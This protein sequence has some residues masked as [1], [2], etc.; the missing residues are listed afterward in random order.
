M[1]ETR[2]TL[3]ELE[4]ADDFANRHIGP[5]EAESIAM[6]KTLGLSSLDE[7]VEKT[8]PGKIR[9]DLPDLPEARSEAQVLAKLRELAGRNQPLTS[10]IGQG[11]HDCILPPVIQRNLLENPGW[12]TAYTPYQAEIAQGRLEALI[13]FQQMVVDLTGLDLAN[14][15]MLDEA[16]AVAE[17]M[18]LMR[19]VG[20]SKSARCF[21]ADDMHPQTLAV[22][23]TRAKPLGIEL[24]IGAPDS[25]FDASDYFGVILQYPNTYG[26]IGDHGKLVERC[27]EGGALVTVASDLLSL[28]KLT[29]PGEW[30]AD[31]VVGSAQRFGVPMAYGGPHAAF[32]A[33]R[34]AYKRS[35]PGRIVGVST[36]SNGDPAL[37]LALQT[38]EQHIR[39]EKATSNICTAQVLLAVIA[40]FYAVWHGPLGLK[41]IANRVHRFTGILAQGLGKLGYEVVNDSWFDT[42]TVKAGPEVLQRAREA[43]INLRPVDDS[44]VGISLDEITTRATL[45]AVL[46]VFADKQD[47]GLDLLKLDEAADSGIPKALQRKSDYLTHPVFNSYHSETEMLRYLR[48]LR[49]KDIALDRSMIPLGSCTMKLN[50]AAE[51][52]AI[53]LP[54]FAAMHPFAPTDQAPG[55]MELIGDLEDW[56]AR[57]TGFDA[58]SLQPNAGS[59]GEYAGLLAIRAYHDSRGDDQRTVCLIPSSAHGTNPASAIMAGMDVVVVGCDEEGNIDLAD[60]EKKASA[61]ADSLAALMVTYPSTHGVFEEEIRRICEIVH[62]NGGQVYMDGANLNAMVGLCQP[63]QFGPDVAHLNLHKTFCIPHGGGGPGVGPIGVRDHLAPFLPNHPVVKEAGPES[64][65]G[66]VAAAPWGSAGILPITWAYLALMGP[67]GLKKASQVAILNANYMAKRLEGHYD[68]LYK[69]RNGLVAHECILD[70]RDFKDTAGISVDDIAKRLMDFGYHAPTM[71]WPVAGTLMAEP[72]ESESRAELDRFCQAM[73]TIRKEIAAIEKGEA[74]KE[75]NPLRNAPHTAEAVLSEDWSHAYSRDQAAYPLNSLREAKYWPPVGRIDN[76][77]GDRNLVCTC[78]PLSAY[79]EAAE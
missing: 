59:Q 64:G 69:G 63:G 54:G 16:T 32:F 9:T 40:G 67:E 73:I 23:K 10:L 27:H 50:A 11:Y 70:T 1:T 77:A 24:D 52:M 42:L 28:L 18:T 71:S 6:L 41:R 35:V 5:D 14:A 4:A 22:L 65:V 31:I 21:V 68:V 43:G 3:S 34:D 75:D 57:I 7:L 76:V 25:D 12:Y 55:Y 60:L 49:E 2:P 58:I 53:T 78:P 38:R 13:N 29:P 30:G 17:A 33:T 66:P 39:R 36:D 48:R 20:K 8:V 62:E 15:S 61:K 72:T 44:H 45:Q 79:Q 19:R 51:M 47:H 37:R 46:S 26:T 74:D 56:L